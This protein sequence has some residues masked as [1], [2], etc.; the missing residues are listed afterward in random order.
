LLLVCVLA[1]FLSSWNY[2]EIFRIVLSNLRSKTPAWLRCDYTC[3][4]DVG[5]VA[6][7][8]R[9]IDWNYEVAMLG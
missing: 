8:E 6:A 1:L 3:D 7:W 2:T 5:E 9:R 4:T